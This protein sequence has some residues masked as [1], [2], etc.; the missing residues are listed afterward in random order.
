M[1]CIILDLETTYIGCYI[2]ASTR[3]LP[4]LQI[5]TATMTPDACAVNCIGY[6]YMA[7]QVNLA[8]TF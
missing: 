6:Q 1:H 2:D 5:N 3:D 4:D 7:T 8:N